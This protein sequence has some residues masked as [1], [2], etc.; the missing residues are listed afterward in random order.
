[1][2]VRVKAGDGVHLPNVHR[3]RVGDGLK[4]LCGQVSVIPLNRFEIL[5]NAVRVMRR[6]ARLG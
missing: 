2:E 5:K 1:M 6:W 4:L 3:S